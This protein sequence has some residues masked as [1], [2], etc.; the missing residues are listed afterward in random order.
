MWVVGGCSGGVTSEN[1]VP[2]VEAPQPADGHADAGE[3]QSGTTAPLPGRTPPTDELG[4]DAASTTLSPTTPPAPA[5]QNPPIAPT[6]FDCAPEAATS[7]LPLRRLSHKQYTRSVRDAVVQVLGERDGVDGDLAPLLAE[8]PVDDRLQLPEALHGTYRRLDQ[9]VQQPHVDAWFTAGVNVGK[10]L[11]EGER[12]TSALGDCSRFGDAEACI[13][14]FVAR[15]GR[16]AFR[17]PLDAAEVDFYYGFYAPSTGIDPRG[18][19]DIVAGLLNAPDFLY[20]VEGR[21]E[22]SSDDAAAYELTA[23][24]IAARLSYHFWNT[25]PDA[26]LANLADSGQLLE[27][28][29]YRAQVERL[30]ADE[31][32][33]D[34]VA[35][36]YAEWLHLEDLPRLDRNN[37]SALFQAFAGEHL[38]SAQ[39][40]EAMRDEVHALL[41]HYTFDDPGG[42]FDLLNSP[43]SFASSPE[44]ANLYGVEVYDGTGTPPR[45]GN[46]RPG[47]LTRAAFLATGTAN[48]RPIMRGLFVRT[49][50]LCDT[51]EPPPAEAGA[52]PPELS[53]DLTTREVVEQLTAPAACYGCHATFINPL[54]FAFEGFDSLGRVRKE[55]RLFDDAGNVMGSKPIDTTSIPRVNL[56]DTTPSRAPEDLMQLLAS[57]GKVEA[58]LARQYFRFAFGRWEQVARDGCALE[59]MRRAAA[60]DGNLATLLREVA[61][62]RAFRTRTLD[63][64]TNGAALNEQAAESER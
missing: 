23:H 2:E 28:E 59:P 29:T 19:A 14:D 51:I 11:S 37:G 20:L 25:L 1:D 22:T 5:T 58:C 24:E 15:F 34:T 33:K 13:R 42:V 39:L 9:R 36:F 8:V 52:T 16:V 60:G 12:L 27:P 64:D 32:T 6:T 41:S 63:L 53:P 49:T 54:G 61:F 46:E 31:R 56:L 3:A 38:P 43:Y 50:M 62:S 55:Q 4:A 47:L 35:E 10:W 57:S 17:R 45:L 7:S 48:T 26:E 21:G 44:L 18:V 40:A 30:F